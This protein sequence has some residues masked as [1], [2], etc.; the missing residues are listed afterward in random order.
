MLNKIEIIGRIG[1]IRISELTGSVITATIAVATVDTFVSADGGVIEDVT[2]FKV[3][4]TQDEQ[5]PNLA[6]LQAGQMIRILGRMKQERFT[7]SGGADRTGYVVVAYKI[8]N[9]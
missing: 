8:T 7:D 4:A 1:S 6:S 2:W 3:L 5:C 9:V